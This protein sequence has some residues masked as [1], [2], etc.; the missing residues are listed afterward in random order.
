MGG[1]GR[2]AH[3]GWLNLTKSGLHKAMDP[4]LNRIKPHTCV[5]RVGT[6]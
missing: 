1:R 6:H 5:D 4:Q 2:A 3:A